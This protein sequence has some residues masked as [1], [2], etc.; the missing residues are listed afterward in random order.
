[1]PHVTWGARGRGIPNA[2]ANTGRGRG[3]RRGRG[4]GQGRGHGLGRGQDHEGMLDD[5]TPHVEEQ[6]GIEAEI[7]QQILRCL[8]GI[9]ARNN[10]PGGGENAQGLQI[11]N[12]NQAVVVDPVMRT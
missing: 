11:P 10:I 8:D 7:L 2:D 4:Q 12:V 5:E 6:G 9:E 1:M 3:G